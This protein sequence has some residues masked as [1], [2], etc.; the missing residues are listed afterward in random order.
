MA[1][2]SGEYGEERV[3]AFR[4]NQGRKM[5]D[6]VRSFSNALA[7]GELHHDADSRLVRHVGNCHRRE[8]YGRDEDGRNLWTLYKERRDSPQKIDLAVAAVLSWEARRAALADGVGLEQE[9]V[10]DRRAAAGE[11]VMPCL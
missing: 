6:A 9:S 1:K 7:T 11:E 5:A 10:W 4:T 2:W 8:A 3:V